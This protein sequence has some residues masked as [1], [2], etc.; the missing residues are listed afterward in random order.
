M[1]RCSVSQRRGPRCCSRDAE[2]P[3]LL[4]RLAKKWILASKL[5]LGIS[6]ATLHYSAPRITQYESFFLGCA[7]YGIQARR[8]ANKSITISTSQPT[9]TE[10]TQSHL[11]PFRSGADCPSWPDR[12]CASSLLLWLI[13]CRTV[14]CNFLCM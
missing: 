7:E 1:F 5:S 6:V 11:S 10:L 9:I 14:F 8:F 12:A 3:Q 13:L 4:L 2:G